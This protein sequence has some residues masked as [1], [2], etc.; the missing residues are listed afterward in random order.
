MVE[1]VSCPIPCAKRDEAI[2]GL[3]KYAQYRTN[4]VVETMVFLAPKEKK[5]Q[6]V[7]NNIKYCKSVFI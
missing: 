5:I 7:V 4:T 6:N 3:A 1:Q 2:Q